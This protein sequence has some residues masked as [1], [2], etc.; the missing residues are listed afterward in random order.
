MVSI[1]EL[2]DMSKSELVDIIR[3]LWTGDGMDAEYVPKAFSTESSYKDAL[4][5]GYID[6]ELEFQSIMP[7]LSNITIEDNTLYLNGDEVKISEKYKTLVLTVKGFT[8][9]GIV[10]TEIIAYMIAKLHSIKVGEYQG[11]DKYFIEYRGHTLVANIKDSLAGL[12]LLKHDHMAKKMYNKMYRSKPMFNWRELDED[13]AIYGSKDISLP[14]AID[15]MMED[16]EEAA[17]VLERA[18]KYAETA[19]L[20]R[21]LGWYNDTY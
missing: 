13:E 18:Q 21:Q 14:N 12:K 8:I 10:K 20:T 2:T 15:S 9:T 17:G 4:Y 16:V 5:S 11:W 1:Q 6:K 7:G 19:L 3:A